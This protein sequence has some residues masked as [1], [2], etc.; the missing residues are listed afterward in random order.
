MALPVVVNLG[1]GHTAAEAVSGVAP[2][3]LQE[4]KMD[5]ERMAWEAVGE[6]MGSSEEAVGWNTVRYKSLD[7]Q[8]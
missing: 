7:T 2:L 4:G 3:V 5:G 8:L 1:A 6:E